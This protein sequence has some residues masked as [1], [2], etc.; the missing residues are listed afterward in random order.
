MAD[1]GETSIPIAE[2]TTG[3]LKAYHDMQIGYERQ[4]SDE[5][6]K[7]YHERWQAQEIATQNLKEYSNEYRGSLNDLSAR[8]ATKDELSTAIRALTEKIDAQEKVNTEFRS[9]LDI[10]NPAVGTIQ[11]QIA[12]QIGARQGT[13]K[14]IGYIMTGLG[15]VSLAIG[16]ILALSG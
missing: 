6:D 4:V 1:K 12:S 5:R 8:M 9:R 2:W 14:T 3:T 10:G 13:D 15:A 7:R 16:I 11:Q